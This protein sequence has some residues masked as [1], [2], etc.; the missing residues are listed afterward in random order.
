FLEQK[1]Q[2]MLTDE[3]WVRAPTDGFLEA[4]DVAV[5]LGGTNLISPLAQIVRMKDNPASAHAAYL[6]L[7]RLTI[8][9]GTATLSALLANPDLMQGREVTRAN[10][11][12]RADVR[13]AAQRRVLEDYL[14]DPALSSAELEKFTGLYPNANYMV[15]HNL[16]TRSVTPDGA[17]LAARDAEALRVTQEWLED[18]RF[19][20]LKPQLETVRRR[21]ATFVQQASR[22]P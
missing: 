13:D 21:L 5:F 7:D 8:A 4:F 9:N 11:F 18:A 3:R 12:A 19:A 10:Y 17:T 15:S 2:I 1:L 16:L 22:S 20:R 14:L 6:A